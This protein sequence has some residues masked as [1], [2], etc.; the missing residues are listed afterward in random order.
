[1]RFNCFHDIFHFFIIIVVVLC[2]KSEGRPEPDDADADNKTPLANGLS[3]FFINGRPV[4][5][6]G[7]RRLPRNPPDCTILDSTIF[8]NLIIAAQ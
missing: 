6:N 5:N 7:T 1:M 3:T 2:A 4:S 8:D